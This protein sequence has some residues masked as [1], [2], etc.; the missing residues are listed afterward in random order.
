MIKKLLPI[1]M[2]FTLVACSDDDNQSSGSSL[3]DLSYINNQT[4]IGQGFNSSG[5]ANQFLDCSG[6][7]I[8]RL[9][10]IFPKNTLIAFGFSGGNTCGG[11]TVQYN[12]T[13]DED[14]NINYVGYYGSTPLSNPDAFDAAQTTSPNDFNA[15][16]GSYTCPQNGLYV[17]SLPTNEAYLKVTFTTNPGLGSQAEQVED[18]EYLDCGSGF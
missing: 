8:S 4:A 2:L 13:P 5:Q 18:V 15:S 9:K 12:C 1:L 7:I 17:D 11:C 14:F 16:G 6:S 10:K 3:G